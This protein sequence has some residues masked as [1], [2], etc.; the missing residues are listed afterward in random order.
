MLTRKWL[1]FSEFT[2]LLFVIWSNSVAQEQNPFDKMKEIAVNK[3]REIGFIRSWATVDGSRKIYIKYD[4]PSGNVGF[5]EERGEESLIV[6]RGKSKSEDKYTYS[7]ARVR[8][9]KVFDT[10]H[11]TEES[12]IKAANIFLQNLH[13]KG[14][15]IPDGTWTYYFVTQEVDIAS[16]LVKETPP[17]SFCFYHKES[18]IA[19][20][21]GIIRVW[22]KMVSASDFNLSSARGESYDGSRQKS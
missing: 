17:L 5:S 15:L 10:K 8:G 19:P 3:G 2:M 11:V 6:N 9:G 13:Y 1:L 16:D 7:Y 20:S 18:I 22:T 21:P 4:E 12:A 14:L